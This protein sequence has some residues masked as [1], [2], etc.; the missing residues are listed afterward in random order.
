VLTRR[1]LSGEPERALPTRS[2]VLHAHFELLHAAR[3]LSIAFRRPLQRVWKAALLTVHH[4]KPRFV[5]Q[6]RTYTAVP[7]LALRRLVPNQ[8]VMR[9]LD[10]FAGSCVGN[11]LNEDV[12]RSCDG[13]R[14]YKA[15]KKK[16]RVSDD[17]SLRSRSLTA[18][19]ARPCR[20]QA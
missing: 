16:P 12:I 1:T 5:N 9:R 15:A 2:P 13:G 3:I 18:L 11:V 7:S 6:G 14:E 4:G 8:L 20:I 17:S 10:S 19:A